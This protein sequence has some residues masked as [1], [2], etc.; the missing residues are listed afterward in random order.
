MR[1]APFC[2]LQTISEFLTYPEALQWLSAARGNAESRLLR[3][4]TFLSASAAVEYE[5][6]LA[7]IGALEV[8]A[9]ADYECVWDLVESRDGG[10]SRREQL[11]WEL[12][13]E[14]EQL[15]REEEE[16]IH[17]ARFGNGLNFYT[18]RDDD[19]NYCIW[20]RWAGDD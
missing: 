13:D 20:R 17:R 2:T 5:D 9:Q 16:R 15:D 6:H 12:R 14:Q 4:E 11:E 10:R 18:E 3:Q 7:H 8:E 1:I 19:L